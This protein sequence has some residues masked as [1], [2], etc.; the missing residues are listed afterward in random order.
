MAITVVNVNV[1]TTAYTVP[2]GKY[3]KFI[4][5]FA[6]MATGTT[7]YIGDY[8][9]LNTIGTTIYTRQIGQKQTSTN[10]F[11]TPGAQYIVLSTYV[12]VYAKV[13]AILREHILVAGQTIYTS[14]TST[15]IKGTLILQDV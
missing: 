4:V 15:S 6:E 3:G 7:I 8:F 5:N 12:E 14:S 13:V 9:S 10:S 11:F 2:S 1:T